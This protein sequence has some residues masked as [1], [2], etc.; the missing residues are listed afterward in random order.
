M[1]EELQDTERA[2]ILKIIQEEVRLPRIAE[3]TETY[4][5]SSES[6]ASNH[7][8]DVSIPP[9][10][11]E[12]RNHDKVP[13]SVPASGMVTV[14]QV[15]DLVLVNYLAGDGDEP[16]ITQVVYGDKTEDRAPLGGDGD[17]RIRRKG[18]VVDIRTDSAD[19]NIV[20]VSRQTADGDPADMGLRLNLTTGEFQIGDGSGYG[21]ESD[22]SGN[23]KWYLQDLDYISDGAK[24]SW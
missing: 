4:T 7:E 17:I 21:I 19:E 6:D 1:S 2:R 3:V 13:I 20:R 16:I 22:G 23:F 15:G 11:N 14:P 24:L 8:A 18:A 12:I 5:H 9:G 10:P